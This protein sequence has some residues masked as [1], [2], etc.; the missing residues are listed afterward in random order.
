MASHA[1]RAGPAMAPSFPEG[2]Y[3][4]L[5]ITVT[6]QG[7]KDQPLLVAG[8]GRHVSPRPAPDKADPGAMGLYFGGGAPHL[9]LNIRQAEQERVL[10]EVRQRLY[11]LALT[12]DNLT[13]PDGDTPA[14]AVTALSPDP[15][16]LSATADSQATAPASHGVEVQWTAAPG[17][18]LSPPQNPVALVDLD[19]GEHTFTLTVDGVEHQLSVM[20]HNSGS[21]V[22]TQ[23]DLLGRLARVIGGA[24]AG[25]SAQVVFGQE[26]AYDPDHRLLNRTARLLIQGVG[27]GQGA[28]FSLADDGGSL[29][30]A[31]HLDSQT[32]P[33]AASLR[34]GGALTSQESNDFSLDNG[35]VSATAK[36]TTKGL[37]ELKVEAGAGPI[38]RQLGSVITQYNGLISYLDSHADL[39]RPSL[40]DRLARPLEDRAAQ[41][42]ALGLRPTAQGR[43]LATTQFALRVGDDYPTV[44]QVL[45][46]SQGWLPAL[47]AKVGQV[48]AMDQEAFGAVLET[49]TLAQERRRA[50]L[51][52]EQTASGILDRY[53]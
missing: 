46:D 35:H 7:I 37:V 23:E 34:L 47:R 8:Q 14:T 26:D 15:Q 48:L 52:L 50:W 42:P 53:F 25:I 40:K 33:R 43:L 16:A 39:L 36:D 6:Y 51:V 38:T 18:V 29:V 45:L 9:N 11:S 10:A 41:M 12:I 28:S 21:Q 27:P 32:P 31:Y 4:D 24:D 30:A 44:R 17:Q 1:R 5:A 20:V 13:P 22:D 2:C 19:D 49:D 3:K